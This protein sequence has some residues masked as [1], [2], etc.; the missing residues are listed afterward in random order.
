MEIVTDH[1]EDGLSALTTS[2]V[3]LPHLNASDT[4][5]SPGCTQPGCAR[6]G[7]SHTSTSIAVA[8]IAC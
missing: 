7:T 6:A 4:Q 8:R 2:N 5:Q 1:N 3:V